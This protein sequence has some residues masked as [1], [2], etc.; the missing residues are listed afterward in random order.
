MSLINE[1]LQ[2]AESEKRSRQGAADEDDDANLS[3]WPAP[4]DDIPYIFGRHQKGLRG[5]IVLGGIVIATVGLVMYFSLPPEHNGFS[6]ARAGG[7]S[8]TAP[9]GSQPA[10][11]SKATAT[12]EAEPEVALAPPKPAPKAAPPSA[13]PKPAV[14]VKTT[15]PPVKP[16]VATAPAVAPP[17]APEDPPLRPA[18]FKLGAILQ[19]N[20]TG[21]ALINDQLVT[22]GDVI[23]GAQVVV[24]RKYHVVIERQGRRLVLRM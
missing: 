10:S 15:P 14:S 3:V 1:A 12:A 16:A 13:P 20:G 18:Y 23:D 9:S 8:A 2:R 19:S 21:Y 4:E 22:A 6:P 7:A 11:G 24:I 5:A 17:A